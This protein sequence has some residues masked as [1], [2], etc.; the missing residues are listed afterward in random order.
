MTR[1]TEARTEETATE[2]RGPSQGDANPLV[3]EVCRS[4][5]KRTI[6]LLTV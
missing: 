1:D 4:L 3:V 6:P 2:G 5:H